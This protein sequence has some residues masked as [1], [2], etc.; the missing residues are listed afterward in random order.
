MNYKIIATPRFRKELKV[1]AKKF[2]SLKIEF[3]ELLQELEHNPTMG[4]PVGNDCYKIRISISSKNKG[5][6]GGA[7][8]ITYV[9]VEGESIFLLS[10]Y[11]KGDQDSISNKELLQLLKEIK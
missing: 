11:S 4:T 5:K 6:S 9:Y 10:I 8:V 7:R 3:F 1:L 2:Q